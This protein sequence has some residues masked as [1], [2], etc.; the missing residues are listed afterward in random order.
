MNPF[1]YRQDCV[2]IVNKVVDDQPYKLCEA[3][4]VLNKKYWNEKYDNVPFYVDMKD[5]A[6]SLIDPS[7]KQKSLYD[8]AKSTRRQ[9][10]FNYN[11]SLA[12]YRYR[13]FLD[14]AAWILQYAPDQKRTP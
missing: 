13:K 9:H 8:I 3:N 7:N 14:K 1:Q 6:P 4:K 5:F 2:K 12:H 11:I 10:L